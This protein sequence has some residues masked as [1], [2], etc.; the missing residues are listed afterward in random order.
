MTAGTAGGNPQEPHGR[1]GDK[2]FPNWFAAYDNYEEAKKRALDLFQEVRD[3][4]PSVAQGKRVPKEAK[5]TDARFPIEPRDQPPCW[6]IGGKI[7]EAEDLLQIPETWE[8]ISDLIEQPM[9][10]SPKKYTVL[11]QGHRDDGYLVEALQAI[12]LREALVRKIMPAYDQ[13]RG[14]YVVLL[15]KNA[16]WVPVVVDDYMPFY[17]GQPMCTTSRREFPSV[18]WP[19]IVQKAYASFHGSYESLG[20]GGSSFEALVDLTG[21]V[22]GKFGVRDISPDRLFVYLHELQGDTLFLA[23]VDATECAKRG[24]KFTARKPYVVNRAVAH[25]GRCFVQLCCPGEA[26]GPFDDAI[27]YSLLRNRFFT[28]KESDGFMWV[29]IEDF[30]NYFAYVTECRLVQD[31]A[32]SG[33]RV[34]LTGCPEPRVL[35]TRPKTLF[36]W[37]TQETVRHETAPDFY[38]TVKGGGPCEIFIMVSQND[39]RYRNQE[40]SEY[41]ASMNVEVYELVT[42]GKTNGY[43]KIAESGIGSRRDTFVCFKAVRRA[44][45]LVRVNMPMGSS[46]E[47]L[48]F[49]CYATEEIGANVVEVPMPEPQ[50]KQK[51]IAPEQALSAN[52]MSFCGRFPE[53]AV[54]NEEEGRGAPRGER[55]DDDDGG[56]CVVS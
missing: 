54:F 15:F 47:K 24:V 53:S 48:I 19:A 14:L 31:G 45:F 21:G 3:Q 44:E 56:G 10:F 51:F 34:M 4:L 32:E 40:R 7:E 42:G 20:D 26:G 46:L 2:R 1:Q 8:R 6:F 37:C 36:F 49:R 41:V 25:E 35:A 38:M 13:E 23:T 16:W 12:A 17:G 29:S 22:G 33:R 50:R 11:E 55:P 5:F 30:Q 52:P 27:P 9:V 39:L 18:C 28:E 43:A